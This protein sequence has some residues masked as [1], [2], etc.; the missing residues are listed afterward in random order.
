MKV[1]ENLDLNQAAAVPEAW[2]TSYQL[3]SIASIKKDDYVL[4]HAVASGVG[5]SLIQLIRFF[6]AKSIG[7]C[8]NQD[9]L[10]HC[11]KLGLN[12]G[13]LRS[14]EKRLEK[15]LDFTNSKGC[16]VILDCVGASE[17]ENVKNFKFLIFIKF[18][19]F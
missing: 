17:F 15:F 11:E 13:L 4:V 9:K 19:L 5:S 12:Y 8:S 1:P 7:L 10:L 2:I 6:K 3:C 14:D 16:D 18:K